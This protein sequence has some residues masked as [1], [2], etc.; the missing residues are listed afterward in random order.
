MASDRRRCQEK[1]NAA[2]SI[3]PTEPSKLVRFA[4][5]RDFQVRQPMRAQLG[6]DLVAQASA[7][8]HGKKRGWPRDLLHLAN[9]IVT[10]KMFGHLSEIGHVARQGRF[11]E[12]RFE[13]GGAAGARPDF[14]RRARV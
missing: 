6:A 13:I 8:V 5:L 10:R 14:G 1:R 12:D 3:T 7:E 2:K 11:E 4:E 9:E